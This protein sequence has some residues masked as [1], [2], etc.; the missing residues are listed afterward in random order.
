MSAEHFRL[1]TQQTVPVTR[2]MAPAD[3][4]GFVFNVAR[5]I[6]PA[7]LEMNIPLNVRDLQGRLHHVT[8]QRSGT[9]LDLMNAIH[10]VTNIVPDSQSL[11]YLSVP[12][13]R[14][15]TLLSYK[16]EAGREIAL[17]MIMPS[18]EVQ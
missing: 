13:V 2:P 11:S 10:G 1:T 16:I 4:P 6:A 3:R 7:R 12:L 18:G 14:T 9:V 5:E 8:V 17:T 15:E